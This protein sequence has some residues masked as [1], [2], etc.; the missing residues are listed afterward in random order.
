MIT[1]FRSQVMQLKVLHNIM[2]KSAKGDNSA[3][4]LQDFAKT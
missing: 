4:Y 1:K 3:K 2:P